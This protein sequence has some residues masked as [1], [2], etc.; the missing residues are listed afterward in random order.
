MEWCLVVLNWLVGVGEKVRT[1][2]T[3][4]LV[5]GPWVLATLKLCYL[6]YVVTVLEYISFV[7]RQQRF[8][9]N[10]IAMLGRER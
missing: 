1:R 5:V 7:M 2:Q 10:F 6:T 4:V 3:I 9:L 8:F